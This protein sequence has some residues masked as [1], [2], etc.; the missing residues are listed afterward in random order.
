MSECVA[1]QAGPGDE[2]TW[3]EEAMST[4]DHFP[5]EEDEELG[6]GEFVQSNGGCGGGE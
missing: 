5:S 3:D 4:V 1:N 2:E 6:S